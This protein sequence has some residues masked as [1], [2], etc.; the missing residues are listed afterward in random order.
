MLNV[1]KNQKES[2][3]RLISRF[4]KRVQ[5]SRVILLLKDKRYRKKP[6]TKRQVRQAAIMR[7]HYRA[8]REKKK[9][10]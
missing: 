3:E 10:Y 9:Y 2:V 4:I 8:I 5:K 7:E 1:V 6:P